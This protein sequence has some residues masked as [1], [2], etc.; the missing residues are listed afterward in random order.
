VRAAFG[1]MA[2]SVVAVALGWRWWCLRLMNAAVLQ[3]FLDTPTHG[4]PCA[5]SVTAGDGLTF[6][7]TRPDGAHCPG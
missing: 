1:R 6:S 5:L 2:L 4:G 7:R 3:S